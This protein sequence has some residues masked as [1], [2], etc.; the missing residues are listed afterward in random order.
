MNMSEVP[1]IAL[2]K[3][4]LSTDKVNFFKLRDASFLNGEHEPFEAHLGSNEIRLE[5]VISSLRQALDM[6]TNKQRTISDV[7]LT[8]RILLKY[9]AKKSLTGQ[10]YI[11][12]TPY[13][14]ICYAT[15]DYHELLELVI[16]ELGVSLI[17]VEDLHGT[18]PLLYAIKYVNFKCVER[19][20]T[21]RA[22]VNVSGNGEIMSPISRLIENMHYIQYYYSNKFISMMNTFELL[23]DNGADVNKPCLIFHRTPIMYAA[24][25]GITK[26]VQKLIQRGAHLYAT[27]RDGF[28]I[29]RWA[30]QGG[31][32]QI[33]R[34][35]LN[36]GVTMT[37][38][39]PQEHVEPCRVCGT[40]LLCFSIHETQRLT[41]LYM[42]AVKLNKI[43]V[44]KL[45]DE[46]G[47]QL[48]K[49]VDTLYYAIYMK[50]MEVVVYLLCK[51]KYPL[52][53]EYFQEGSYRRG[54]FLNQTLLLKFCK[55]DSAESAQMV[56][57]LLQ[58]GADPN[59]MSCN[60]RYSTISAINGAIDARH[61]EVIALLIRGGA[62][63]YTKSHYPVVGSVLPFE[64]AVYN[65]H[66]YAADMLL[67]SGCPCGVHMNNHDLQVGI[68]RE[69][70][71]L[72][73]EW[74]VEKNDVI[75]L[76]QRC[77]MVIL[78]QLT[79]QADK[80]ILELPLPLRLIKY[81]SI[82]ELDN[83]IVAVKNDPHTSTYVK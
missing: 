39:I 32:I 31:N 14:V 35:L 26:C 38:Y 59:V 54:M 46:Y 4:Q 58:H 19:L 69:L 65:D 24:V 25:G 56:K 13:H 81:L 55:T 28:I 47:C 70:K 67:L 75:P 83:I 72:L 78:N 52:N 8:L 53:N 49:S 6:V 22:D 12:E 1:R 63:L 71:E 44:V 73:K 9:G 5:W 23:L 10:Y 74:N 34:Y 48:Y 42:Q 76:K 18:T 51:H 62:N 50:S 21:N 45:I 82:P 29:L 3:E 80:K 30:V 33:V 7:T 37:T 66:I 2:T 61:V 17:N 11:D 36:L 43:E 79:P 57:L 40:N 68:T 64:N 15:G 77:R 16:E 20:I 41:D 60:E 27:D